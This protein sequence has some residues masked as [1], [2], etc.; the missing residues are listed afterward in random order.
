MVELLA[1]LQVHQ[2]VKAP[3]EL[4]DLQLLVPQDVIKEIFPL[5]LPTSSR[6][7]DRKM[8]FLRLLQQKSKF[9][10]AI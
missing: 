3:V 9:N 8:K 2:A 5:F 4:L 6:N 7:Q 1:D 10:A